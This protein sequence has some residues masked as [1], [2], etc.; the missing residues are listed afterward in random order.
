M[1]KIDSNVL[2]QMINS[3]DVFVVYNTHGYGVYLVYKHL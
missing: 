1:I 3:D 2:D